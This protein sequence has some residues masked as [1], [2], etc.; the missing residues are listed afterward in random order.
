MPTKEVQPSAIEA[1]ANVIL[2]RTALEMR[3]LLREM[4][5]EL[6]PFPFFSGSL[7]QAVEV[8]PAPAVRS[9][10][11]CVVVCPDGELYELILRFQTEGGPFSSGLDVSKDEELRKLDLPPLEYIPYAYGAI[12]ELA[13]LLEAKSKP[14]SPQPS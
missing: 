12:C 7:V 4:A 13:R 8:E 11:G 5:K 9:D 2:D 14:D 6:I 10:L 1:R 3:E